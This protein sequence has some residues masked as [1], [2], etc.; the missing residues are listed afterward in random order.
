MK[1]ENEL[2]LFSKYPLGNYVSIWA[3]MKY[4]A[5]QQ[6]H[7]GPKGQG[8]KL[9]NTGVIWKCFTK[10]IGLSNRNTK[11]NVTRKVKIWWQTD[12]D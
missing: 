12:A 4:H 1:P 2:N 5:P 8:Q 7:L 10:G 11:S 6:G 9:V 3:I